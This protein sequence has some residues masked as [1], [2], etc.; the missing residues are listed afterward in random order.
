M[1]VSIKVDLSENVEISENVW[2]SE[3]KV[4]R[5]AL[6]AAVLV[7]HF[8]EC[9]A[10]DSPPLS[11]VSQNHLALN[12]SFSFALALSPTAL[13]TLGNENEIP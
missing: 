8:A 12:R 13:V 2:T 5:A 11:L 10:P 7:A 6:E 1:L 3:L 4:E 9:T